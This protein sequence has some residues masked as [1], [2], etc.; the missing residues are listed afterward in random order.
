MRR[1]LLWLN[2]MQLIATGFGDMGRAHCREW[3][4]DSPII[5]QHGEGTLQGRE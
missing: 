4:E 5:I 2:A 1:E 3:N